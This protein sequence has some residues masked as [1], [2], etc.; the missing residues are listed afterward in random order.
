MAPTALLVKVPRCAARN[1][2][3]DVDKIPLSWNI[4]EY[5]IVISKTKRRST[6]VMQHLYLLCGL[7]PW[8]F[9]TFHIIIG[10]NYPN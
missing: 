4:L 8:N 6:K 9:R 3:V 7:E 10:N 1:F 2:I 5:F